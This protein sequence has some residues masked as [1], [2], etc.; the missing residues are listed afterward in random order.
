MVETLGS[1]WQG[2]IGI[3]RNSINY[4]KKMF[5]S[6]QKLLGSRLDY[7]NFFLDHIIDT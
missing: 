3:T 4:K 5:Y 2:P 1:E 7:A 6:G